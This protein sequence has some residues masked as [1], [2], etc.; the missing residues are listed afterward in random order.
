MSTELASNEWATVYKHTDFVEL[1][2]QAT[3]SEMNDAGVRATEAMLAAA[4]E[5]TP[6]ARLMIDATQFLHKAGDGVRS[7]LQDHIVPR[8]GGAGVRRLA[9]VMRAGFTYVGQDVTDSDAVY[10]TRW[11]TTHEEAA[12]WLREI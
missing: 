4:V 6:T 9:R 1:R 7:W 12:A 2:W 11:F 5:R 3:S 10:V 8:L